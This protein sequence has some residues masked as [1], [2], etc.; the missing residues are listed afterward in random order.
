MDNRSKTR[1][2]RMKILYTAFACVLLGVVLFTMLSY[3]YLDTE[4]TAFH[5]LHLETRHVKEN[6]EIQI[7]S[8]MENLSTLA[9]LAAKL[10]SNGENFDLLFKSFNPIGLIENI[11]ILMSDGMLYTKTGSADMNEKIS[12]NSEAVKGKC[13]SGR[14]DDLTIS[15]RQIIRCSV[16]V[17]SNGE[18]VAVLYGVIELKT[19]REKYEHFADEINAHLFIVE[20]ENGQFIVDT[21]H[22]KLEN[23]STVKNKKFKDEFS[24][25]ILSDNIF[26]KKSGYSAY[27]ENED[28]GYFYVHYSPMEVDGWT[29]ML[30]RPEQLVFKDAYNTRNIIFIMYALII[31]IVMLYISFVFDSERKEAKLNLAASAIRKQLLVINR[32]FNNIKTALE[33][34]TFFARSRSAFFVDTRGEDYNYINSEHKNELLDLDERKYFITMLLAYAE[35]HRIENR[36]VYVSRFETGKKLKKSNIAFNDFLV[37]HKISNVVFAVVADTREHMS[38]LGVV[39]PK[40]KYSS[41][42][43]LKD[44]AVCFSMAVYNKNHLIKTE[45]IAVTDSLTGLSNR[46]AYK[47][48]VEHF[49]TYLPEN[50]SCIYLDVNELHFINNKFGHSVGDDMLLYIANSLSQ[51]FYG[52]NVY[53]MGGDEFLVFLRGTEKEEV[54]QMINEFDKKITEKNYHVSIGMD[55]VVKNIDTVS[56]VKNAEKRMYEAKAKYYQQKDQENVKSVQVE[57]TEHCITGIREIDALL[58]VASIRYIAVEYVSL[59]KDASKQILISENT[60]EY[61]ENEKRYTDAFTRYVLDKVKP[62]YKRSMLA[63]LEYDVLKK[64]LLEGYTPSIKYEKNTGEAMRLTVYGITE[65]DDVN[66]TIWIFEKNN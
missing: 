57:N 29:I 4:K 50:F 36:I 63:F 9:N 44:I 45:T 49:N 66:D 25:E 26:S 3:I 58:S 41:E 20:S 8:D 10:H 65:N 22:D 52:H 28:S 13:V 24:Y 31:F 43:L 46:M 51:I 40:K 2:M 56:V 35:E 17:V 53:R 15:G 7:V 61:M 42:I 60:K 59:N 33:N 34:I 18:Y 11:G 64:Q 16:P 5:D 30:S 1:N 23:I 62:D 55:Y 21:C 19:L 6:I 37:A 12:F 47:R 38:I 32:N 39:N 54:Q 48:D 27:I 14:V